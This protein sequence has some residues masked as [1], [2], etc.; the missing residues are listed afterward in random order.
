MPQNCQPVTRSRIASLISTLDTTVS[1]VADGDY[2][3]WICLSQSMN[4]TETV[5]MIRVEFLCLGSKSNGRIYF[6]FEGNQI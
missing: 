3:F 4:L 5:L 6:K 1:A 2:F